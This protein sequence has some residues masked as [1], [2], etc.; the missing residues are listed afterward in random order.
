MADC[1]HCLDGMFGRI[2]HA[3]VA[4]YCA[5]VTQ[6]H[7]SVAGFHS[8]PNCP[9][10]FYISCDLTVQVPMSEPMLAPDVMRRAIFRSTQA[11]R[12]KLLMNT[13]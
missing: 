12:L 10:T 4:R 9:V 5:T 2:S 1:Y 3:Q 11:Y 6:S 8:R 13:H 7:H